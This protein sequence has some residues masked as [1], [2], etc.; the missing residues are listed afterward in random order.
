MIVSV[1]FRISDYAPRTPER[2]GVRYV[3]T[4]PHLVNFR[5]PESGEE[6]VVEPCGVLVNAKPVEV[7]AGE[8]NGIKLVRTAFEADPASL[9]ELEAIERSL[10]R[11]IVI[12]SII[13]AQAYP[14]RVLAMTPCPGYERVAPAEKRMNPRKF[15]TFA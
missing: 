12:G 10:P 5:D 7:E 8:R 6:F 2:N 15:T 9:A 4:T 3:N 11:A 14:G 13:A 1:K